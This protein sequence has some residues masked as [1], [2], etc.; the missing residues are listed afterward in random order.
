MAALKLRLIDLSKTTWNSMGLQEI[1]AGIKDGLSVKEIDDM[2]MRLLGNIVYST[3][4]TLSRKVNVELLDPISQW[5]DD[6]DWMNRFQ[7][8]EDRT[9][10]WAACKRKQRQWSKQQK[11]L[12]RER[13]RLYRE[14]ILR[15]RKFRNGISQLIS[16][17]LPGQ[18]IGLRLDQ[19][20]IRP[21]ISPFSLP[22]QGWQ[23]TLRQFRQVLSLPVSDLLPWKLLLKTELTEAKKLRELRRYFPDKRKDTVAKLVHL[24]EMENQGWLCITQDNPFGE[25][26]IKPY[27]IT[28]DASITV[29]DR[30]GQN[31]IFDWHY[32]T[33]KQKEKIITDIKTKRIIWRHADAK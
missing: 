24:L 26:K 32:L 7:I 20:F 29:T 13:L 14:D 9:P 5:V 17:A 25:I 4:M 8:C 23:E 22:E 21:I 10:N 16:K 27:E 19:D 1:E 12:A 2:D 30:Q 15:K 31:Y 18:N 3:V 33:G 6:P 28:T 11:M